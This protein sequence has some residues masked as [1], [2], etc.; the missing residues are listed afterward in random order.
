MFPP[1][2]ADGVLGAAYLPTDGYLDPS[3]LTFALVEGARRRGAEIYK[4]TR[5]IGIDVRDGGVRGV[6]TDCGD[7]DTELVVNAGGMFATEIGR[8][9]GVNVPI[10]P[11]AHEYL[12]TPPFPGLPLAT[13]FRRC[14]TPSLL[15]YFRE[16]AGGLVMGGYERDRAPWAIDEHSRPHPRGL[17]R[18]AA[19]AGLGPIRADR[20]TNRDRADARDGRRRGRRGWSTAPRRSPRTASSCLGESAVRGF[21]VA[22]GFCAHGLAGAGGV[23]RLMAEWI[24]AGEPTWTR[25]RWTCAA[26]AATTAPSYTLARPKRSM[27]PTTT[28]VPGP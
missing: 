20:W 21:F 6:I 12:V 2:S 22:A 25:G 17:Q 11:F 1:M 5:V 18:P 8:L 19:G 15:V 26:S 14:A 9:A 16:D 13:T 7:I 24:I 4:H 3:Q 27:R 28:S 23:G 10:V